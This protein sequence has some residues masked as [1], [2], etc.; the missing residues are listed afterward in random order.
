M[1]L[2]LILQNLWAASRTSKANTAANHS[3]P[4]PYSAFVHMGEPAEHSLSHLDI[5]ASDTP[6]WEWT[7]NQCR[8]W[9]VA[10]CTSYLSYPLIDAQDIAARFKGFGPNIY[11]MNR[12]E[13]YR[14]LG[15]ENGEGVYLILI[16]RRHNKGA[17]PARVHLR[18]GWRNPEDNK[19]GLATRL[20]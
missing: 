17:V 3:Q 12:F 13:W 15:L 6:Q 16:D 19:I 9:I 14:L 1:Q 10:V 20:W 5:K 2:P 4:P 18:H 7:S 8:A 11:I